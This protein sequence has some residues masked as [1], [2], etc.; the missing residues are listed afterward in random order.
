[1]ASYPCESNADT[2]P[3]LL[4]HRRQHTTRIQFLAVECIMPMLIHSSRGSFQNV[5]VYPSCSSRLAT[6]INAPLS[7]IQID[8]FDSMILF[9]HDSYPI[10]QLL[11]LSKKLPS[12]PPLTMD[13]MGLREEDFL[14]SSGLR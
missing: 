9:T 4:C 5:G 1:M 12:V 7:S 10:S 3:G 6:T 11:R 13:L 14:P 8:G 2:H